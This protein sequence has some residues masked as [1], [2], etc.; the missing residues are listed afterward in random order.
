MDRLRPHPSVTASTNSSVEPP[1]PVQPLEWFNRG[2]DRL[3]LRLPAEAIRYFDTAETLGWDKP[4]CAAQRWICWMLLGE[5]EEAWRESEGIAAE[6]GAAPGCLWDGQPLTGGRVLIRCLHGFGDAIQFLRYAPLLKSCGAR[7]VVESALELTALLRAQ[8]FIDEVISWGDGSSD[9]YSA[10]DQQIE[11]MELPRAHRTTLGSIPN[12]VPYLSVPEEHR[13]RASRLMEPFARPRIGIV[14]GAS[15]WNPLRNLPASELECLL[16]VRG[17]SFHSLQHGTARKEL[18]QLQQRYEIHDTAP[19]AP[20]I[21]DTAAFLLQLDLLICVDTMVA[22]LGGALGVPVWTL[23]LHNSDWRWMLD[24]DRS[25]W[26][27]TMR[28]FRQP[29]AGDWQ[30]PMRRAAAALMQLVAETSSRG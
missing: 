18:P 30:T 27:P 28:L 7:V 1:E 21:L 24:G 4:A 29:K 17:A 6:G 20:D 3:A 2:I 19:L 25:P 11:V 16:N 26:Y 9:D 5:L 14:W 8:P 23:L 22:H 12:Q 10:W 13:K 15:D